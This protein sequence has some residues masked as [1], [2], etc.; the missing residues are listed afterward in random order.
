MGSTRQA[1]KPATELQHVWSNG[2]GQREYDAKSL[3]FHR[4]K[5]IDA[6]KL[7]TDTANFE[8]MWWGTRNSSHC[9]V[10]DNGGLMGFDG[11]FMGF[12]KRLT[13]DFSMGISNEFHPKW[14]IATVITVMTSWDETWDERWDDQWSMGPLS[15]SPQLLHQFRRI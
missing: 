3:A 9:C 8:E 5:G 11:K 14:E 2:S 7:Q 1:S 6:V 15:R 13:W 12:F 4:L 10:I